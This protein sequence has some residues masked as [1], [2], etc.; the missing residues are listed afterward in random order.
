MSEIKPGFRFKN[1]MMDCE[2]IKFAEKEKANVALLFCH[3]D[4]LYIT[5]RD[6]QLW[7]GG[8]IW[9]YGH[10]YSD[11]QGASEDYEVRKSNL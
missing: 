7:N 6:L 11:K 9:H 4:G 1:G 5:V 10:Y 3:S 8:Y 2:V